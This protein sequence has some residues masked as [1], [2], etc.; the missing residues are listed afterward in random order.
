MDNEGFE[1]SEF[2]MFELLYMGSEI[3]TF[4]IEETISD[5]SR[6]PF[7]IVAAMEEFEG[8]PLVYGRRHTDVD[9][10]PPPAL[11]HVKATR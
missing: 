5:R 10:E 7:E 11:P 2:S 1:Q 9:V 4:I 3:L 8:Q 6:D